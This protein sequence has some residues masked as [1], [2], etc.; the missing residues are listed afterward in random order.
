M[1]KRVLLPSAF[2]SLLSCLVAYA[3]LANSEVHAQRERVVGPSVK[4]TASVTKVETR[5]AAFSRAAVTNSKLRSSLQWA[6]GGKTQTGWDIYVPL[7]SNTIGTDSGPDSDEFATAISKWQSKSGL[8]ETG[9]VD[10]A[11]LETFTRYWQSRRLG[12]A[13]LSSADALL[14]APIVEFYDPTR[15][16]DLLQLEKETYAAYRRMIAAAAADLKHEL[17]L[18]PRGD[19]D[20]NEKFLRIVS[21]YRSPEYQAAL[22]KKEPNAGRAALAKNSPHSTGH[23]LD[24][25]VGG[26]PVKTL[27]SNRLIQVQTPAYKWLV[28][29]AHRFGFYPY[30]YE[31]WHWEYVPG[32]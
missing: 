2:V 11:T 24:I 17:K 21:A 31:P 28:K 27:D 26:E 18:T 7:I 19:L 14:S 32:R 22:R 13:G 6:F 15:A 9:I 5:N 8:P 23:A 20:P 30:F 12:R 10:S 29:N 3:L 16:P 4:Q 25:Y 1:K